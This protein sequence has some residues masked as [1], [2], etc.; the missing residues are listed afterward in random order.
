MTE[1]K[2]DR[3][4]QNDQTNSDTSPA[5]T[6]LSRFE[7]LLERI[8]DGNSDHT[9]HSDADTYSSRFDKILDQIPDE[10]SDKNNKEE[11]I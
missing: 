6:D 5:N 10:R 2:K 4:T 1:P 11:N 3:E 8:E 9:N 7:K